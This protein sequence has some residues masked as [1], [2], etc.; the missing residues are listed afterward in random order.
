M[1]DVRE[2]TTM[3]KG[4]VTL[5]GLH[6]IRLQGILQ[7]GAHSPFGLKV[8]SGHGLIIIGVAHHD[9]PQTLFQVSDRGCQA[10]DGH[11]L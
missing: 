11:D 10:E 2:G 8:M 4:R 3:D 5:Q 7:Q 6:Q 1:G 9:T